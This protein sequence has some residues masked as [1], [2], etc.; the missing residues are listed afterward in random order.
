LNSWLTILVLIP[1]GACGKPTYPQGKI[2]YTN[3]CQSCHMSDGIGLESVIPTL[4]DS[5]YLQ[6]D[7]LRTV[8]IIRNG[9]KDTIRVNGRDF[10]QPM[11]AIPQLSDFEITNILNYIHTSWGNE[12]PY[13]TLR[14]VRERLAECR[15][16]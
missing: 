5:D 2:L 10:T 3:F 12:L 4:V 14:Q 9:L 8:C 7:P 16:D 1:L 11:A 6:E 13:V 15:E